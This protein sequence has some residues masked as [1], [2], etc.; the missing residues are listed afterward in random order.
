MTRPRCFGTGFEAIM[1][2]CS[3]FGAIPS[4][5]DEMVPINAHFPG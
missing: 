5:N 4:E 2:N 3:K 1:N